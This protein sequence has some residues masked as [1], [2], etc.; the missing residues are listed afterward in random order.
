[1]AAGVTLTIFVAGCATPPDL[2]ELE[3]A[4]TLRA[5]RVP[6]SFEDTAFGRSVSASVVASPILGRGAAAL[7][8]AEAGLLAETGSFM[9][10]LSAGVRP[11]NEAGF[12]LS[13][14]G[15]LT[16]LVYD[17]GSSVSRQTAAQARVF[18]GMAGHYYAGSEA[19]LEAVQAWAEVATARAIVMATEDSLSLLEA[20]VARIE[21][22]ARSGAGAS[23]EVLV[24]RSR[25]ANERAAAVNA[26]AEAARAEAVFLE[27]FGRAPG[28]EI[29]LPPQA[30]A[31]AYDN[32]EGSAVLRQAEAAVLAAEAEHA[33]ALA[34]RVPSVSLVASVVAGAQ[35][36]AGVTSEQLLTPARSRKAQVASAVASIQARKIE[37]DATQRELASRYQI[38]GADIRAAEQRLRAA[39]TANETT[40]AYLLAAREQFE[41]GGQTLI[42][43]LDA[44][45][46]ALA[47]ERQLIRAEHDNAV[48]G[49]AMLAATG[50]ILDAFGIELPEPERGDVLE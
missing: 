28:P 37:L 19:V 46:E 42:A 15:S 49:Y 10:Q 21:D 25:L 7:R 33:A 34:E 1:M 16:Q 12:S 26:A 2:T 27:V 36:V 23:G 24:A 11:G 38:L 22:R 29:D 17:G 50:D 32:I 40:K 30:P 20:T 18:G 45:R 6:A 13:G 48:L 5:A 14:F 9:P 44:Q 8:Q 43:L 41:A 35:V 47:A 4:V 39:Q 31:A 3:A